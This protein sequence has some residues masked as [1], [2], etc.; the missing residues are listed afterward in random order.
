MLVACREPGNAH[1]EG[2][3]T[4]SWAPV[5]L[6]LVES[7]ILVAQSRRSGPRDRTRPRCSS[8]T[9]VRGPYTQHLTTRLAVTAMHSCRPPAALQRRP[10]AKSR[11]LPAPHI[12]THPSLRRHIP[13]HAPRASPEKYDAAVHAAVQMCAR[14]WQA[15]S[16][17]LALL[18]PPSSPPTPRPQRV[19]DGNLPHKVRGQIKQSLN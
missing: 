4:S 9:A 11:A 8:G 3:L 10:L 7:A 14:T 6:A 5:A 2:K 15:P 1:A 16:A 17:H 18:V 12:L 13:H 19:T